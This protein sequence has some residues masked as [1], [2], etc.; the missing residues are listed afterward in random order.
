MAGPLGLFS[1][2]PCQPSAGRGVGASI[3]SIPSSCEPDSKRSHGVLGEWKVAFR[4]RSEVS[5]HMYINYPNQHRKL[6]LEPWEWVSDNGD[7]GFSSGTIW[8]VAAASHGRGVVGS[9]MHRRK[10]R[11]EKGWCVV[12]S[13]YASRRWVLIQALS[14]KQIIFSQ[15]PG[16]PL[17]CPSRAPEPGLGSPIMHTQNPPFPQSVPSGRFQVCVR[18]VIQSKLPSQPRGPKSYPLLPAERKARFPRLSNDMPA[19]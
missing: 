6:I 4:Q 13:Q 7:Q 9:S 15:R 11:A 14:A 17:H 16:R 10:P 3:I 2:E 8:N 12:V 1:C 5:V 18:R 19:F